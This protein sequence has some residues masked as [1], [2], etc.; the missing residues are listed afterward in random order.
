MMSRRI[1]SAIAAFTLACTALYAIPA[2]P[3]KFIHTQPDGTTIEIELHGDEFAHWATDNSG[4]IV[5]LGD[6]GFYRPSSTDM[7]TIRR[8]RAQASRRSFNAQK[9]ASYDY[10]M[11]HGSRH[12]LV[13]LVEFSDKS[14]SVSSPKQAFTDLLNQRG[15]SGN[16]G[17]GSVWDFYNDNSGGQFDPIF[18][19]YGPVKLDNNMAYYG[20]NDS[21][22]NDQRPEVALYHAC[23]KLDSQVD[24][25]VY[26]SDGDGYVDM[27][28]FYYAGYNEAEG[29]PK[30]SIWPHQWN[31]QYSGNSAARNATFD[32]KKLDAYFCTSELKGA[33]GTNMCGVGTTC[34]EFAHSLGLP[35][36]YDTDYEDNGS[37]GGLYYFSTMCSGSYNN[38]GR[39]PPFF[40]AEER[41]MLGWMEESA[42]RELTPGL[43][44]IQSVDKNVAYKSYTA[45]EGEYFVYECRGK[46]SPWDA[47]LPGG[48]LVYHA[49]KS[50]T[51]YVGGVSAY[52]HWANWTSY[53]AINA[54]GSHP[55]FYIIPSVR[56]TSLNYNSSYP[57]DY[58][59]P[60]T[61]SISTYIPID[62]DGNET[63]VTISG[64]SYS[65]SVVSLQASLEDGRK[66]FGTVKDRQGSAIQE[67]TIS[68]YAD[69]AA[70]TPLFA[71]KTDSYGSY[72]IDLSDY[73]GETAVIKVKKSGYVGDMRTITLS[74][75]GNNEN[76]VLRLNG[77][78]TSDTLMKFDPEEGLSVWGSNSIMAAVC[79]TENEL[80]A[81]TGRL[82]KQVEFYLNCKSVES[83]YIII[84]AGNERLLTAK[85]NNPSINSS[86]VTDLTVDISSYGIKVPSGKPLYIGYAVVNAVSIQ[87]G[88]P[89]VVI[90]SSGEYGNSYTSDISYLNSTSQ[91][92]ALGYNASYAYNLCLS[93]V[94]E[95]TEAPD[96]PE[97][98]DLSGVTLSTLGY[99]YINPGSG[100]YTAG[101]TF[102]L[103]LVQAPDHAPS[104]VEWYINGESL[105]GPSVVLTAGEHT[106]SAFLTYP[107]G[108]D[109][110]LDLD[111]TVQ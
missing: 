110:T 12:I 80:Q 99:N 111:I 13:V 21:N 98:P 63:G 26:D 85:V 19:V 71:A 27:T 104:S 64:I 82:I 83:L 97:D 49:D 107:D 43:V 59:F 101:S 93:A 74:T 73:D 96:D 90:T 100:N 66:V 30:N 9:R 65:N 89:P 70:D 6:D 95:D 87:S 108:S 32:G 35:D 50:T 109:E 79:F 11:T 8:R 92:Q 62:W 78:K 52:N 33:S 5:E 36:F 105:S 72:S 56:Q 81:H 76:F 17:T 84:D 48:L 61:S 60:G 18:D 106:I 53:N 40:N 23:L 69:E 46:V 103:N 25:S 2:R 7:S 75:R 15:Y 41:I 88:Y 31:L 24:F 55:C 34:H 4:R 42:M 29:G 20:G 38:D 58:M 10:A 57:N 91:W 16:G 39:T 28:L 94:V 67:A 22:G 3:G 51:H 102:N 47:P 54:Y 86:G 1:F 68:V 14:F 37:A 45:T 44:T 77:E